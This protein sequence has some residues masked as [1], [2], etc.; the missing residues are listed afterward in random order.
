ME[1]SSTNVY[2]SWCGFVEG[3]L[4]V[5]LLMVL[6][7]QRSVKKTLK[8]RLCKGFERHFYNKIIIRTIFSY[9]Y[10][11]SY[12][13]AFIP[14]L[15]FGRSIKTIKFSKCKCYGNEKYF[16]FFFIASHTL[17]QWY[18]KYNSLL[19]MGFQSYLLTC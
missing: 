3:V 18:A 9:S 10:K 13:L 1:I 6:C 19:Q 4:Q 12:K 14:F 2:V 17:L 11:H 16:C 5:V 15:S 8:Q 7:F